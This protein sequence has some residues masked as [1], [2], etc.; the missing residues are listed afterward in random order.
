MDLDE[1]ADQLYAVTPDDFMTRRTA[2][3]AEAKESGDRSLAKQITGLRKPTRSA[4]LVNLLARAESDRVAELR[5]LGTAL[6]QAQQLMAG[7]ELR[8]LSKQRRTLID[9][10]ARRAAEL[11][12]AQGYAAP[13]SAVQEVSQT[14]QAA[15]ADP[16]V[17]EVVQAGRLHQAVNYGGFGPDDLASALAASVPAGAKTAASAPKGVAEPEADDAQTRARSEKA[18]KARAAADAASAAAAEAE[19]A[20]DEATAHADEL[21][22]QVESLRTQLRETE[23]A[24]REA[25][26]QAR[27]AR[28]RYTELRREAA[29][30][31]QAAAR[32]EQ[33]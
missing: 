27:A 21:A 7:D 26:E 10:L 3:A 17:A 30:A 19:T 5:E 32:A 9:T 25:R 29:A 13:D 24:E 6:Q 8:Q 33:A 4:W 18:T 23:D 22:D 11:G 28:K 20:A 12:A 14:L 16:A 31:E 1:A 2:L 15:L